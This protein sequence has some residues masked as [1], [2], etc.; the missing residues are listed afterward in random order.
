[1][2]QSWLRKDNLNIKRLWDQHKTSSDLENKKNLGNELIKEIC[3]HNNLETRHLYPEIRKNLP[4]GDQLVRR[5]LEDNLNIESSLN[6]L[7][8]LS[9]DN[10]QW[11][12]NLNEVIR[13]TM[14]HME[15]LE[16]NI[17]PE[18]EKHLNADQIKNLAQRIEQSRNS[19]PTR[20]HP[21]LPKEGIMATIANAMA[22]PAD[23]M[24][25][26][27]MGRTK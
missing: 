7:T 11:D 1:M 8:K 24:A 9:P 12:S 3:I 14:S 25:D 26:T 15:H 21:H 27:I 10:T 5:A 22:A 2:L 13:L 4:N 6:E 17:L 20:P 23:R 19:M 16:S 18:M